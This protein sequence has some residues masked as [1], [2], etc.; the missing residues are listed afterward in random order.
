MKF[1]FVHLP[2]YSSLPLELKFRLERFL[3][4]CQPNFIY[5]LSIRIFLRWWGNVPSKLEKS[6]YISPSCL[7]GPNI[8]YM[9]PTIKVQFVKLRRWRRVYCGTIIIIWQRVMNIISYIFAKVIMFNYN[10]YALLAFLYLD[11]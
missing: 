3:I 1:K 11:K 7:L 9:S 4:H 5:V 8:F 6:Q 10:F 2:L